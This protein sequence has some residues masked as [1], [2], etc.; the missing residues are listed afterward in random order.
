MIDKMIKVM[1]LHLVLKLFVSQYI[2]LIKQYHICTVY[3]TKLYI[4]IDSKIG[5]LVVDRI[6]KE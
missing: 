5:W 4:L 6:I 1:Y 2:Q 3:V